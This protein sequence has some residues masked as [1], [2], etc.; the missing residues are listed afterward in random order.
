[1][2]IEKIKEDTKL[3]LILRGRVDT[4]TAPLLAQEI[5]ASLENVTELVLDFD[6]V[7]YISSACLRVL[8][9][10]QKIINANRAIQDVFEMTGF[11][12]FVNIKYKK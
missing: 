12:T 3:T 4:V 8:L 9:S 10:T 5:D 1:M 6:S 2:N 11:S 7:D